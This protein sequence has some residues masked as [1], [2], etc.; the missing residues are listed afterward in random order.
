MAASKLS[1]VLIPRR[2][3]DEG[4][5]ISQSPIWSG[6]GL[7]SFGRSHAAQARLGGQGCI[8]HGPTARSEH[9]GP[10]AD[11]A[12]ATETVERR[13]AELDDQQTS[14]RVNQIMRS[15]AERKKQPAINRCC[16]KS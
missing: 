10:I 4:K 11:G 8:Q 1:R 6:G 2:L 15:L 16:W 14:Q 5:I 3:R 12:R 9:L 7:A 13:D